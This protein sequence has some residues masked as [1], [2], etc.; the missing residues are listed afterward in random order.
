M[1]LND[2]RLF[3]AS[4]EQ[5]IGSARA[6]R[7]DEADAYTKPMGFESRLLRLLLRS[8]GDAPLRIGVRDSIPV[9]AGGADGADGAAR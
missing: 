4:G 6:S 1:K 3:D 9:S 2:T 5:A 8:L 7:R